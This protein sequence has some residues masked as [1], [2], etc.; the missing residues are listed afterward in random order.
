MTSL[1]CGDVCPETAIPTG[2]TAITK[3][4][5]L[6]I[7]TS[8]RAVARNS[9]TIPTA[10][11][12]AAVTTTGV[13]IGVVLTGVAAPGATAARV[14]PEIIARGAAAAIIATARS[15]W[16]ELAA[17]SKSF[18][19]IVPIGCTKS[20]DFATM[21]GCIRQNWTWSSKASANRWA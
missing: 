21:N 5:T 14:T 6:T 17:T 7:I 4:N 12:I 11:A 13:T 3:A 8:I 16:S 9:T 15:S 20:K 19:A 1:T 2:V 10:V 18:A